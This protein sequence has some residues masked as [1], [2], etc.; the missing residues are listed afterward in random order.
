MAVRKLQASWWVD[1]SFN[2]VRYRK[3][4]P[5]NSKAGAKAYEAVLLQKLARGHPLDQDPEKQRLTFEEFAWT[6]YDEY[7]IPNN[8]YL[9]QRMKRYIIRSSLI[10]FFGKMTLNQ[11][12]T[13][14]VEQYKAL[15]LR[16]GL[17]RKTV[18]NR[19]A[20]FR[21]CIAAAYEWCKC[22]GTPPKVL[23]LKCPPPATNYLSADQ[24]ALL[25]S[26]AHG[27]VGEMILTALR[28][29]MRQGELRGLQWS[30]INWES[31]TVTVRHSLNDRTKRLEPPKNNR[32]RHIPLDVDVYEML[33]RR[34]KTTGYVFSDSDGQPFDSQRLV[35]RLRAVRKK[36]GLRDFGWHTLRHTFASHLAMKGA[37][38][39]VVQALLGHSTITMT[40]RYAHVAPSTLRTAIG[41]L[42]PKTAISADFGQPVGNEWLAMQQRETPSRNISL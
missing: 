21:R 1:F 39:H 19:L 3:R 29:G 9:E 31:R 35:R 41:L 37:P 14:H 11:I 23:W 17:A 12:T 22:S 15:T 16:K 32:E 25:L 33:Y 13:H 27:V 34:K 4:S 10:P 42:N 26:H 30:S 28:S 36:A 5:D 40:M 20:V 8:K 2:Y 18:N 7:V 6:W 38:L 24:C